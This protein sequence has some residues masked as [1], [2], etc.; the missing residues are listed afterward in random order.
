MLVVNDGCERRFIA[1]GQPQSGIPQEI[2]GASDGESLR[3]SL[4]D[5]LAVTKN[6]VSDGLC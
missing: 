1:K 2:V 3:S 5:L 6:C 4:F